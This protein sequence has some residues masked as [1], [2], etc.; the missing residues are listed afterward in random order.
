[1]YY[2]VNYYPILQPL[3]GSFARSPEAKIFA[4]EDDELIAELE[5]G[6]AAMGTL[7]AHVR[8][9]EHAVLNSRNL[10]SLSNCLHSFAF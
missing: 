9:S 1:M 7:G 10:A 6:Q 5:E 8:A 3:F 2:P 4:P